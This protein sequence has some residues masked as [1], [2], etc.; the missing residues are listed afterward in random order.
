[1]TLESC[2]CGKRRPFFTLKHCLKCQWVHN[3]IKM[4][5]FYEPLRVMIF[6]PHSSYYSSLFRSTL[7]TLWLFVL[8]FVPH[9]HQFLVLHFHFLVFEFVAWSQPH[10][11]RRDTEIQRL[12][13]LM[14]SCASIVSTIKSCNNEWNDMNFSCHGKCKQTLKRTA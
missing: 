8:S 10:S 2:G 7:R 12:V 13:I 6:I 9:S 5:R 14:K 11:T 3:R 1:M 4:C